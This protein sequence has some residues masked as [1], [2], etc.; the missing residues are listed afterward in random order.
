MKQEYVAYLVTAAITLLT[1]YLVTHYVPS[2]GAM[3]GLQAATPGT[4]D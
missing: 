2:V 4:Q 1:I 3:V